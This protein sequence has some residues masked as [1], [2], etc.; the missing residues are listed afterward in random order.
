LKIKSQSCL[1][2]LVV[3]IVSESLRCFQR[4]FLPTEGIYWYFKTAV[5]LEVIEGINL[6][7][8]VDDGKRIIFNVDFGFLFL[9]NALIQ[10]PIKF[11]DK[12]AYLFPNTFFEIF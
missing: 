6:F 1:D 11:Y 4:I 9:E 5:R 3:V 7:V 8:I 2:V 12:V 10:R